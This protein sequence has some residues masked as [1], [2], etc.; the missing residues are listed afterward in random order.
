MQ[1]VRNEGCDIG[2]KSD[3]TAERHP[4]CLLCRHEH[5]ADAT[6]IFH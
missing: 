1:E 4:I 6:C 3:D 2:R 5:A